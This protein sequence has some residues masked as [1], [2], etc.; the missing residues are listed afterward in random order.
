MADV[1]GEVPAFD[2]HLGGLLQALVVALGNHRPL[3]RG[4]AVGPRRQFAAS[5]VQYGDGRVRLHWLRE[6]D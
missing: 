4:L 5:V 3:D 1:A 2:P 6:G